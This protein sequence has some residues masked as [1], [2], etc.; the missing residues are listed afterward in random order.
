MLLTLTRCLGKDG[1][2][3][4]VY[5]SSL[6]RNQSVSPGW[7]GTDQERTSWQRM[8]EKSAVGREVLGQNRPRTQL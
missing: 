3:D 7:P 5:E 6:I 1:E 2:P 8:K 4:D